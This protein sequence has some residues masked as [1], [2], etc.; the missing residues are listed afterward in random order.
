HA[1]I[2]GPNGMGMTDLGT[3]TRDGFASVARGIN[4][5]GQVVGV[6]TKF[7]TFE[8]EREQYAFITGPNGMGM[9]GLDSFA[10]LPDGAY[11][12]DA[13]GI[14]NQG[15]VVASAGLILEPASYALMLAGLGLVGFMARRKK[16]W[17]A[18]FANR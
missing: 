5:S 2:T 12:S 14:N 1:F 9:T 17:Q 3:L 11:L 18:G 4:D 10:D 16:H 6:S 15:Q 7:A 13:W 8:G